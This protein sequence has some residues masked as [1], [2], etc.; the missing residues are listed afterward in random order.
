MNLLI[1]VLYNPCVCFSK[2]VSFFRAL[3]PK[4]TS[5]DYGQAVCGATLKDNPTSNSKTA[6]Y[7]SSRY[8]KMN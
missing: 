7:A 3:T 6:H 2:Q 4:V 1:T 5:S 8:K